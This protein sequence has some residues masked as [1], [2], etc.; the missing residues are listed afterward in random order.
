[1]TVDVHEANLR[2]SI[3][4]TESQNPVFPFESSNQTHHTFDDSGIQID[5]SGMQITRKS[6]TGK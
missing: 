1:M 6:L 5:E 4:A 2:Q 3:F